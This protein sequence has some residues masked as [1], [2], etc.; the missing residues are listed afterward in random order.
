MDFGHFMRFDLGR[1]N[2]ASLMRARRLS[3][4]LPFA[5]LV[6]KGRRRLMKRSFTISS[7][8]SFDSCSKMEMT[9]LANSVAFRHSPI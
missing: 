2:K 7:S 3:M 5:S 1:D 9:T 4:V 6:A 8:V